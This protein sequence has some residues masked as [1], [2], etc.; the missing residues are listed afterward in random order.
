MVTSIVHGSAAAS[1]PTAEPMA[2]KS[3]TAPHA[4]LIEMA[5][6]IWR[7]RALYAA[8][9]LGLA[10]LLADGARA[11]EDLAADT[12]THAPSL[13]RLLRA[14]AACGLF[15]EVQSKVFS[16]TPL[17]AAMQRNAPG[18]ARATILTLAGDWQWKAWDKFLES[19]RTG[20]PGL[21]KS[22]GR[23]LFEFLTVNPDDGAQFDEAMIGMHGALGPALLQAYDF[24]TFPT[25]V[26]VGGGSGR[27]LEILLGANEEQCG[28]LFERPETAALARARFCSSELAGRCQI[29]EGDFFRSI[30]SGH[31]AYM[32]S[33]VLHDWD[34]EQCVSILRNCRKAIAPQGRLL[35]IEAVL[36]P[37]D[38]PHHGKMMDLLMLNVTGGRERTAAEFTELLRIAQFAVLSI[39]ATS[40]HQS[41]VEAAPI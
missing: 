36:P 10:D 41:V 28:I 40:T 16:V 5:I 3:D 23:S 7:A 26:D 33:H 38:S 1:V 20:E 2:A 34:D 32:L 29:V 35:I 31:G 4:Q 11:A 21:K 18:A 13:Y 22:C 37:G 14:L 19:L 17:G 24:S 12:K 30:P 39:I 9:A 15:H 25:I 27:L 6:A 8:A